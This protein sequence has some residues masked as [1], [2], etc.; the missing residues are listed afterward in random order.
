MIL[1]PIVLL[2]AAV[3]G[4]AMSRKALSPV[5]AIAA[6]A[7]RINDRNLESR[8]P[9][10]GTRDELADMS[11]TL[12]QMLDRIEAGYRSVR[13]FTANAA[14]ELRTPVSLICTETE[15]SLAFSTHLRGISQTPANTC[16][17]RNR[18]GCG[19]L[20][21]TLLALTRAD[22]GTEAL[23]M[24]V[25]DLNDLLF[26]VAR[27]WAPQMEKSSIQYVVIPAPGEAPIVGDRQS[28]KRLLDIFI[29]N[30]VKYTPAGGSICVN[31]LCDGHRATLAVRD[32]GIGISP[33]ELPA[34]FRALLPF[35]RPSKMETTLG[36]GLGLALSA[37]DR[38]KTHRTT[39]TMAWCKTA[40]EKGVLLSLAFDCVGEQGLTRSYRKGA[41]CYIP[42]AGGS[43]LSAR[44]GNSVRNPPL[45]RMQCSD[46]KLS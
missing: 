43:H 45:L 37:M 38:R 40:R 32:T 20:I 16:N 42:D 18:C 14:H 6:E 29:D 5:A 26:D 25:L 46:W 3:V 27:R 17:E 7:R 21:E 31:V 24:D 35:R 36:R 44:L 23:H 9:T 28:L 33:D 41:R 4:Y 12:N 10:L 34:H 8:L 39:I 30:A 1:T 13:E 2:M 22:A 19:K 11:E 15:V